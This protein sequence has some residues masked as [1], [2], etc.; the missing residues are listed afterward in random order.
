MMCPYDWQSEMSGA[1]DTLTALWVGDATHIVTVGTNGTILRSSGDGSWDY[2]AAPLG[3]GV[4]RA[5]L[6]DVWG[7]GPGDL[8][9]VGQGGAIIHSTGDGKWSAQVSGTKVAL[10]AVSGTS[11]TDV[12]AAGQAGTLLHSVGDGVWTTIPLP[13]AE[14]LLHLEHDGSRGI[15]VASALTLF[16]STGG[17]WVAEPFEQGLELHALHPSAS[18]DLYA[19]AANSD[20]NASYVL[21]AIGSGGWERMLTVPAGHGTV[22]SIGGNASDLYA[23]GARGVLAR[24]P[25]DGKGQ[26]SEQRS[27]IT[28]V[29]YAVGSS[30]PS[31]VFAVGED[32]LILRRR[33][34]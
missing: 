33:F 19:T 25:V 6:H 32:G 16:R 12:Y 5:T 23:A 9:A 20:G 34:R 2:D 18:G 8:Y 1:G 28:S 24:G 7:S 31:A 14:A 29:F 3:L 17:A 27:S 21:R 22:E 30:E 26:W 4:G 10:Y 11:P 13:T 15:L